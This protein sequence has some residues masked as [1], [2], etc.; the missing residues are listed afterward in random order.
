MQEDFEVDNVGNCDKRTHEELKVFDFILRKESCTQSHTHCINN[1]FKNKAR[2]DLAKELGHKYRIEI[3]E[4]FIARV[5][6]SVA[7]AMR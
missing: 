7:P 1:V 3:L 4:K 6:I 2:E 5:A